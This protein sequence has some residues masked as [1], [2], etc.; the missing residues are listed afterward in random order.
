MYTSSMADRRRDRGLLAEDAAATWLARVGLEVVARNVRLSR[1]EIDLV[2]RDRD[3]Y[4]FVEVKARRAAWGDPASAAVTRDKQRRLVQ[5]AYAYLKWKGLE[6]RRCRF[7]VVSVTIGA[8]GTPSA[9][10][11]L[12]A[13]FSEEAW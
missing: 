8:D 9:I 3:T 7:D 5:L 12:P 11:H 13:A 4:V 1:G 2:C 10:R 6:R